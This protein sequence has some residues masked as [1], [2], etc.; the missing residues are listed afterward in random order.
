VTQSFSCSHKTFS[1]SSPYKVDEGNG[2]ELREQ[3]KNLKGGI[4]LWKRKQQENLLLRRSTSA[5][6]LTLDGANI[7]IRQEAGGENFFLFG[8]TAGKVFDMKVRGYNP[9]GYYESN[10]NLQEIIDQIKL[11]YFLKGDRNLFK[12]LIDSLRDR[13][14]YMLLADYRIVDTLIFTSNT[15]NIF[16]DVREIQN[17]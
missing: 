13:D 9:R 5:S 14:E 8:L 1:L 17:F 15:H 3:R 6:V 2:N 16:P 10:A 7:E 4:I 11:G 12:P